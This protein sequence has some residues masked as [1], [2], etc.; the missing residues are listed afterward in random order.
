MGIVCH[1]SPLPSPIAPSN[2]NRTEMWTII[3]V[4]CIPPIRPLFVKVFKVIQSS[5]GQSQAK[6]GDTPEYL[7]SGPY[8]SRSNIKRAQLDTTNESEENILEGN[9]IMLTRKIS[10][11][12]EESGGSMNNKD[13]V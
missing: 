13:T 2:R 8:A 3:M 5:S 10:I 6:N 7:H 11:H 9:G 1:P 12:Y 4:S